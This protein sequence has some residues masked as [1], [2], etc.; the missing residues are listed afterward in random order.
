MSTSEESSAPV[1][2]QLLSDLHLQNSPQL[3]SYKIP[4]EA[5]YL[6][7]AGDIGSLGKSKNKNRPR[8]FQEQEKFRAFL[9]KQCDQ[10]KHV[11]I[12]AGNHEYWH[13]AIPFGKDSLRSFAQDPRMNGRLTVLDQ[14]RYDLKDEE[15]VLVTIL[16]VTLW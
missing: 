3:Y 9:G 14:G 8:D 2:F 10:F 11:F 12:I 15:K 5:D 7:L 1:K 6:L 16:G 4:Q 13:N